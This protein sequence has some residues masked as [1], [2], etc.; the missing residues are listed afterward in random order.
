MQPFYGFSAL[1]LALI[2]PYF[3][4][5]VSVYQMFGVIQFT[6]IKLYLIWSALYLVYSIPTWIKTG[7]FS[8]G[9]FKDYGF[10]LITSGSYY[11]LWYLASLIYALPLFFLC[12]K[13]INNRKV[14]LV[15]TIVLYLVK[16][17]S[18]GYYEW[19]PN[20]VKSILALCY[21]FSA[22]FDAAF[23]I[24]PLL[25]L[26][27]F[28]RHNSIK[29]IWFSLLGFVLSFGFLFA[30]AFTLKSFGGE[31]VSFILMTF[32]TAYF[33][34]LSVSHIQ[35]KRCGRIISM[36]GWASLMIYC[37]HPMALELFDDFVTNSVF[38]YFCTATVSMTFAI[39]IY[40]IP[41]IYHK[42]IHGERR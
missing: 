13:H 17:I 33:F 10:A 29:F 2:I 26:G 16:A 37:F 25:L 31:K 30:E 1:F 7:W 12:V 15:I 8:L 5:F 40:S 22:L 39:I 6:L 4:C 41:Q 18:Y 19:L 32:P 3:A 34:F 20:V 42:S 14:L 24:L 27:Y 23:L 28:I 35:I 36:L 9:A 11:H 38:L 21:K